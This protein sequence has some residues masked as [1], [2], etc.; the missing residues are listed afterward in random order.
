[1]TE[2]D[3]L[4]REWVL[5][6]L[7]K[8]REELDRTIDNIRTN[9]E[10]DEKWFGISIKHIYE[11]LNIAWNERKATNIGTINARR[12][13]EDIAKKIRAQVRY[14]KRAER[15]IR[16]EM[17]EEEIKTKEIVKQKV[18]DYVREHREADVMDLI[19]QYENFGCDIEMLVE[20][21][22]ELRSE[23]IKIGEPM[24]ECLSY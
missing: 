2:Q 10:Y 11:H 21:I 18:L 9:E 15:A 23:L 4:N 17:S 5:T 13:P 12:F 6:H 7:E 19:E 14:V 20:V 22:D 1:M 3:R 24:R 16:R 8:A